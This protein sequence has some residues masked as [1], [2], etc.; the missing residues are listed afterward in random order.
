[1]IKE[2]SN[3]IDAILTNYYQ[4]DADMTNLIINKL[5]NKYN[6]LFIRYLKYFLYPGKNNRP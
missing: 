3:L 1:M 4:V 5:L 2:L 6:S